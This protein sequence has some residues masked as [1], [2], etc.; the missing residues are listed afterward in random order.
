MTSFLAFTVVGIVT[1][2]IYALAASGLVVTYTTSGVFN[3]AHGA[4]GMIMTFLYWELRFHRHWPAP[5]ALIVVLF[6]AAPLFG[7]LVERLLMRG[8]Y[9]A[10]VETSLVVTLGLLLVLLGGA[11]VVWDPSKAR[12]FPEFFSGRTV[13]LV[14][15]VVSYHE[16]VVVATAVLAAVLLRVLFFRTAIGVAMRAV[17]DN[18]DLTGLT[19]ASPARIAQL[20]W[21]LGAML[22][23]VAGILLASRV[24]LDTFV[25][26]FLVIN[27]YAAAMTGRLK[28]LPLTFAGSLLLGLLQSYAV[29]YLPSQS[30]LVTRLKPSLPTVFLLVALL[31]I[32]DTR[33]KVGRAISNRG[34]R[35]P[36]LRTSLVAGC[37]FVAAIVV[38]SGLLTSGTIANLSGGLALALVMLSVV[39]LTGY[40]GQISLCQ[41]TMA[42]FGAFAMGRFGAGGSP[43]GLL[44]AAALTA[45]IGALVALPAL[46]LQGLYFALFTLSFALFADN[47]VFQDKNVFDLGGR[48]KVPRIHLP[49]FTFSSERS[50]LVLLSVV[51]VVG[52]VGLLAVRRGPLGRTLAAVRDSPAA[53]ATLGLSLTATRLAVFTGAAAMAGVAGALYG[54]LRTSVGSADF[55][56][57]NSLV[58]LLLVTVGGIDTV[59]G[60]LVGG[61]TFALFPVL[62]QHVPALRNLAFLGTGLAT[63]TLGR[64]PKG[65]VGAVSGAW[66]QVRGRWR[67]RM[68]MPSEASSGGASGA[69]LPTWSAMETETVG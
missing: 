41:M 21:A 52:A 19:G 69:S 10:P 13:H 48:L 63:A 47:V 25:L 15:V 16:V 36:S 68:P 38:V 11:T 61:I 34:G 35:I 29:G 64:N 32:P 14:G 2:A 49:G 24:N 28:S 67:A 26:T 7:A 9:G 44:A 3:F 54:S 27:A 60:A 58:L 37:G 57:L 56:M 43:L 39:L 23:A 46:R 66:E 1:G 17:V 22:S 5:L 55:V 18:R 4:M 65:T 51:F 62:Q 33:L 8:I 50:M 40:G 31:L 59:T 30:A 6:V 53:C 45:P 12:P 20:S 42:G